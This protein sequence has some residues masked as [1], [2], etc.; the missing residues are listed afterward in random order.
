MQPERPC[1]IKRK[2]EGGQGQEASDHS[3]SVEDR[4]EHRELV[5]TVL[6]RQRRRH[7]E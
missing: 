2:L 4:C 6:C 5:G 7:A 3:F 1:R